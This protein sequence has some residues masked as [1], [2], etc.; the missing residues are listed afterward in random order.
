MCLDR[1]DNQA[2]AD[3]DGSRKNPKPEK[4]QKSRTVPQRQVHALFGGSMNA[5]LFA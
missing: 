1:L 2:G 5:R 3:S 4:C